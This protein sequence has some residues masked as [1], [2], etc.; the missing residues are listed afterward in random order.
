MFIFAFQYWLLRELK[1]PTETKPHPIT[2]QTQVLNPP[3][4]GYAYPVIDPLNDPLAP[5]AKMTI[6]NPV[7]TTE[8]KESNQQAPKKYYEVTTGSDI[9]VQ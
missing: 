7:P 5:V 8:V 9:L 2:Q 4:P 1:T 6:S 3:M